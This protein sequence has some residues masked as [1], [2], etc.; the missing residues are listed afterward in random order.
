MTQA[1]TYRHTCLKTA[2]GDSQHVLFQLHACMRSD[3]DKQAKKDADCL[4]IQANYC[5]VRQW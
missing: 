5:D 3:G 1:A 4:F 2:V